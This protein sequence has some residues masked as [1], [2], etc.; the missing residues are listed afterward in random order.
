MKGKWW[1]AVIALCCFLLIDVSALKEPEKVII[2]VDTSA[3]VRTSFDLDDDLAVLIGL[4]SPEIDI[5][6]ITTTFGNANV[7]DTYLN[8]QYLLQLTGFN[9]KI[10]LLQGAEFILRGNHKPTPASSFITETLRKNPPK[11]ISLICLGPLSN[12]AS[13]ITQDPSIVPLIKRVIM[14]GGNTQNAYP[15]GLDVDLNFMADRDAANLVLASAVPKYLIPKQTCLQVTMS[16]EW[17]TSLFQNCSCPSSYV[18]LLEESLHQWANIIPY[19]LDFVFPEEQFPQRS[20][21]RGFVPWDVTAVLYA[22]NP[23][24]FS[25]E[26][27]FGMH[28]KGFYTIATEQSQATEDAIASLNHTN[29]V[30]V[31]KV[32][33]ETAALQV[34]ASKL[35]SIQLK[36][37]LDLA[38]LKQQLVI[39]GYYY[40]IIGAFGILIGLIVIC[41][42]VSLKHNK[43]KK[44]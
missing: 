40:H 2:D 21:N 32:V 5:V 25:E 27:I 31:P 12:L 29:H 1:V 44:E 8:A 14:M 10:P 43:S 42:V 16:P 34:A 3:F 19:F 37:N 35:C 38:T 33:N 22:T 9:E 36:S 17:I 23:E 30:I 18:C 20:K 15:N 13:A 7:H 6:G 4:S 39:N 28:V 26:S 11:T 41:F 24:L